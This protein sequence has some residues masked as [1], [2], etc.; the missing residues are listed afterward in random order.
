MDGQNVNWK[1]PSKC[2]QLHRCSWDW[3]KNQ[4]TSMSHAGEEVR[5]VEILSTTFFEKFYLRWLELMNSATFFHGGEGCLCAEFSTTS[6]YQIDPFLFLSRFLMFWTVTMHR[7]KFCNSVS[8]LRNFQS[9]I[10]ECNIFGG[11][12]TVNI[13]RSIKKLVTW[14]INPEN[15]SVYKSIKN[16]DS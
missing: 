9:K 15:I 14:V 3:H 2:L 11:L 13:K 1:N 16:Y 10:V 8:F 12:G 5:S 7:L 4:Y 6:T